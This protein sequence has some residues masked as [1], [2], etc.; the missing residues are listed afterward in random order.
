M[1][2]DAFASNTMFT[3]TTLSAL[4]IQMN[5]YGGKNSVFSYSG[6]KNSILATASGNF[7]YNFHFYTE[8][9]EEKK[10]HLI[11]SE[12]SMDV[13]EPRDSPRPP[14]QIASNHLN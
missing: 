3:N 12:T 7:E 9:C 13:G 6:K 8:I 10:S 2:K 4:A 14:L 5:R 1:I 11:G